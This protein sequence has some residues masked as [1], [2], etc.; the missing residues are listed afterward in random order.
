MIQSLSSLSESSTLTTLVMTPNLSSLI[1]SESVPLK[2]LTQTT[3]TRFFQGKLTHASPSCGSEQCFLNKCRSTCSTGFSL[4]SFPLLL[5]RISKHTLTFNRLLPWLILVTH[6]TSPELLHVVTTIGHLL[7]HI[8]VYAFTH[9][10]LALILSN[11]QKHH[12]SYTQWDWIIL[13]LTQNRT[14]SISSHHCHKKPTCAA[15]SSIVIF[16]SRSSPLSFLLTTRTWSS[17]SLW[18]NLQ[19]WTSNLLHWT[20]FEVSKYQ[21][22][23]SFQNL[24]NAS[25]RWTL[26]C[27]FL[28]TPEPWN[29]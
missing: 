15:T 4:R 7:Q 5:T 3:M 19:P 22:S 29:H 6:T 9:L 13:A 17:T 2:P 26:P 12:I 18:L 21:H 8:L 28:F 27:N 25:S 1:S 14:P 24:I 10:F 23:V 20:D 16:E 11:Y